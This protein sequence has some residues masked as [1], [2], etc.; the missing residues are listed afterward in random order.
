VLNEVILGSA[1][2]FVTLVLSIFS[3]HLR[4]VPGYYFAAARGIW[5]I[6]AVFRLFRLRKRQSV[7]LEDEESR[8]EEIA[9]W[10]GALGSS[11]L[12]PLFWILFVLQIRVF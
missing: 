7:Q 10:A 1:F 9:Y 8:R 2:P 12:A 3:V 11:L 4:L 5:A 6:Y